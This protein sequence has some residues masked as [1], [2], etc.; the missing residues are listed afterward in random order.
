AQKATSVVVAAHQLADTALRRQLTELMSTSE[1]S[2]A[3]AERWRTL[4]TVSGAVRWIEQL[5]NERLTCALGCLD[6]VEIPEM[7]RAALEDMAVIC[8]ERA[9]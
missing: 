4:I 9:A 8:T 7:T 1:L 5:I 6:S 2:P 3:D